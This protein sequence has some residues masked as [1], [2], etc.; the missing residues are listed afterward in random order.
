ML[1]DRSQ[2]KEAAPLGLEIARAIAIARL[3]LPEVPLV[4]APISLLGA[5]LAHIALY[6][7]AQ[8]LGYIAL[9]MTAAEQSGLLRLQDIVGEFLVDEMEML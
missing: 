8:D 6:C 4:R 2:P 5:K 9:D 3:V 1:L 7:G